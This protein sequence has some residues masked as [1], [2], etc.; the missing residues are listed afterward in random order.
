[1]GREIEHYSKKLCRQANNE[2]TTRQIVVKE[3]SAGIHVVTYEVG[4]V[5]GKEGNTIG[6]DFY[7]VLRKR[8]STLEEGI[9]A[10]ETTVQSSLSSGFLEVTAD[11][12]DES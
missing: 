4:P 9:S 1:M 8:Y 12:G 2:T 7:P 6:Y 3:N 10:A 5:K 11:T